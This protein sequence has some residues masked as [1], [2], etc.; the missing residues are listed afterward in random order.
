M[1]D[2]LTCTAE[3]HVVLLPNRMHSE[4]LYWVSLIWKCHESCTVFIP[5]QFTFVF[6]VWV[7]GFL[8]WFGFGFQKR[9]IYWLKTVTREIFL[10]S[11]ETQGSW[12]HQMLWKTCNKA[13]ITNTA[14]LTAGSRLASPQAPVKGQLTLTD[15]FFSFKIH[16]L[17]KK[18]YLAFNRNF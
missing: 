5:W 2:P 4:L 16:L 7:V 17:S 13:S 12:I 14:S 9:N 3:H 8:F 18:P 15:T 1:I 11:S 10:H 6:K